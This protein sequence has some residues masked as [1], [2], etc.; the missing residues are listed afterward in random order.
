MNPDTR[1][2]ASVSAGDWSLLLRRWPR[3]RA[4]N[5]ARSASSHLMQ[6][7]GPSD[8]VLVVTVCVFGVGTKSWRLPQRTIRRDG[9]PTAER[10]TKKTKCRCAKLTRTNSQ[11]RSVRKRRRDAAVRVRL[12]NQGNTCRMCA[13]FSG[14]LCMQLAFPLV[15]ATKRC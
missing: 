1:S 4:M 3:W 10:P 9:V 12:E 14:I 2:P 8:T 13:Y 11:K 5:C 7:T 15:F 6:L